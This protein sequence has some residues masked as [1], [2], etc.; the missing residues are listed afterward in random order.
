M[1]HVHLVRQV[2]QLPVSVAD[3][4]AFFSNAKNLGLITPPH[5]QLRL[6]NKLHGDEI[7]PGQII[8]YTVKPL[9]RI[10]L[11]WMTEITH[12]E[13]HKLFVDEQ[14]KGPYALW[15]HQHH[16]K[17]VAGGTEMT[18]IVHY[19]LPFGIFGGIGKPLVRRQLDELF[20]YRL[21]KVEE[22]FGEMG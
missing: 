20:A 5:L 19:K 16:F 6:T 1:S 15:H 3:A 9:F 13:R 8:T 21:R 14:R 22:L 2:Q 18:D 7:Y 11:F 17:P 10:P 12:V 4:W